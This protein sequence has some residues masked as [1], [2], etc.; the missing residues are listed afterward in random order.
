MEKDRNEK[1][2]SQQKEMEDGE[3]IGKR[4]KGIN[5]AHGKAWGPITT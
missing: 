1:N 4:Y 5:V 2:R 3:S